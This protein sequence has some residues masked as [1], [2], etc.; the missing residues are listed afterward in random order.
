[1]QADSSWSRGPAPRFRSLGS[2]SHSDPNEARVIRQFVEALLFEGLVEFRSNPRSGVSSEADFEPIYDHIFEFKVGADDYR[3]FATTKSFGRIRVAEG[4]VQ[5]EGGRAPYV[6]ELIESLPIVQDKKQRLERELMQTVE[7]SRWNREHLDHQ[8]RPRRNLGFQELESAIVEGHLYHPSFKTRTGFSLNDHEKFGSE[9]GQSFQLEWLGV[10]QSLLRQALP[11]EAAEFWRRE[12]GEDDYVATQKELTRRGLD[13]RAYALLPVHPWQLRSIRS[14]LEEFI[15]AAEVVELGR[16]GDF[17]QAT[18]SLRTLVNVSRP[19]KANVKLPLNI[20]CTS[21]HRNLESH[22]VCTAPLLSDWLAQLVAEDPYLS[23]GPRVLLLKEYAG[24][25]FEPSAANSS[26]PSSDAEPSELEGM[27]GAIFRESV[28][29]TLAEG[30]VAVPF[31]ALMVTE[32]DSRPFID[33]WLE[34]YGTEVW[35]DR[36]IEVV[37][38]PL[39]HMLVHHGVAFEAHAQNL[40]LIHRDGWP[41]RIVLRDFHEDTEFVPAY[42]GRPDL[43]PRFERVDPYFETIPDDDGYRMASTEALRQLF[44]DTVYVFNLADLAFLL[45]RY[46]GLAE[47]KFWSM[48]RKH[49]LAYQHAGITEKSRIEQVSSSAALIVVE[50]LLKKK[51]LGG[52]VLDYFEHTVANTLQG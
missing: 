10:A 13:P 43:E 7:V 44:M 47:S 26:D 33:D 6:L 50:S 31:T 52:G 48:V 17:Y 15:L 42:L 8:Y 27:L 23:A 45:E 29:N 5:R 19:Q 1:M 35:T 4:S 2:H 20:V 40:V 34:K 37:V 41:E 16:H 22:F 28:L 36:L 14:L 30:E 24:L 32:C 3:C 39:W 25:I 21:S 38:L 46:R 9:A 49:L 12:L 51:L 11:G 18:Q